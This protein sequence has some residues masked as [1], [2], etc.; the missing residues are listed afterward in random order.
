MS[1][2]RTT[3]VKIDTRGDLVRLWGCD[4]HDPTSA[5]PPA[6]A[7]PGPRGAEGTRHRCPV[8]YLGR[9]SP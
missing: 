5:A 9:G 6:A 4:P 2:G 3:D 7:G 8:N 1:G